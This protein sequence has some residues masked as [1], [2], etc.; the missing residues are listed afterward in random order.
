[1]SQ[2]NTEALTRLKYEERGVK[3]AIAQLEHQRRS[4]VDSLNIYDGYDQDKL[5]AIAAISEMIQMVEIHAR[6][7]G[8][9]A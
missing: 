8:L 5:V 6:H 4:L 9:I 3:Y 1:M 2:E 7:D